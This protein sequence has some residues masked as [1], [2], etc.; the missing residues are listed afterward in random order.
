M[1]IEKL[2]RFEK[3]IK[4][5]A[6][7]FGLDFFETEFLIIPNEKMLEIMAY[8]LP[9]NY[10]H[11][12]F[13]RDYEILR[14][15]YEHGFGLPYEVVLNT[16]PSRAYLM[17]NNPFV[18]NVLVMAH[19][20]S[21]GDFM[22]NN[23]YFRNTRRDMLTQAEAA[24]ERFT[25]YEQDHGIDIVEKTIDAA[26]AIQ[27]HLGFSLF[28]KEKKD[29]KR[30]SKKK[31]SQ[32]NLSSFDYLNEGSK[33]DKNKK[34]NKKE[35]ERKREDVI[36]FIAENSRKLKDWQKDVLFTIREQMHYL[37]PQIETKIM[38]EGWATYWHE[39]IM[40]ELFKRKY[41]TDKDHGIFNYYHSRVIASNKLRL[42][43]YL[44]G[45]FIFKDIED[46]WNR[47]AFGDKYKK[48][49]PYSKAKYNLNLGKGE[50]KIFEVRKVYNDQMF[51]REFLTKELVDK[52]ELY[53]YKEMVNRQTG[54]KRY[55]I[56]ERNWKKIRD[57][58]VRSRYFMFPVIVVD[59][60][61][62]KKNEPYL[63]LEHIFDGLPLDEEY[64]QKTLEYIH[65]LW[66]A[67]VILLTYEIE[68]SKVK[69][70]LYIVKKKKI[71]KK[72]L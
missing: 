13:G 16:R 56:V 19:V 21:H 6:K 63:W 43:P 8:H 7:D 9:G 44:V 45:S 67:P 52:L 47:G 64:T 58:L 65:F 40:H 39:K 38:N 10:S 66:G 23:S 25:K 50:E 57:L 35:N 70:V 30:P 20:L 29:K 12:S 69:K 5:I 1:K 33:E 22:K 24:S 60:K 41:L 42:N 37:F 59:E 4:K 68:N 51:L 32:R 71:K 18:L 62:T 28:E 61:R 17:E 72:Y 15:K 46:R 14:T 54:E 34:E 48:L 31:R 49:G 36:G 3:I 27:Y 26:H 11:W 55:V 53:I 2:K